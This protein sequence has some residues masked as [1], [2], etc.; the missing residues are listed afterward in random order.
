MIKLVKFKDNNPP[1]QAANVSVKI[2]II[3]A[4]QSKID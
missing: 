2:N 1:L 4:N 3:E